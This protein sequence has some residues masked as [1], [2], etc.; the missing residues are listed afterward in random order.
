MAR[1][2]VRFAGAGVNFQVRVC[3]CGFWCGC[4]F[5][6]VDIQVCFLM[7]INYLPS[8]KTCKHN[9][10]QNKELLC[11]VRSLAFRS[12]HKAKRHSFWGS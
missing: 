7:L 10:S 3:G 11:D 1:V 8:Y 4:T 6:D 12:S 2:R 9:L 5:S